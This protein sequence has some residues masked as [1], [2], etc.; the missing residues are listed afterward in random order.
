MGG[1]DFLGVD[2]LRGE[3]LIGMEVSECELSRGKYYR[4][5]ESTRIYAKHSFY[6]FYF[7]VGNPI[8]RVEILWG[9]IQ[10]K[11]SAELEFSGGYL[12]GGGGISRNYPMGNYYQKKLSIGKLF[13]VSMSRVGFKGLLRKFLPK[14]LFQDNIHWIDDGRLNG[15]KWN[16]RKKFAKGNLQ[17]GWNCLWIGF[18]WKG[19]YVGE[20]FHRGIFLRDFPWKMSV[21]WVF[22][23]K[24]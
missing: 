23:E 2:F 12:C 14:Y 13:V 16:F 20:T 19:F 4:E 17:R 7:L 1:E 21:S 18:K 15:R 6:L 10:G 5:G 22:F 24:R 9:I 8:L 11:F 3:F